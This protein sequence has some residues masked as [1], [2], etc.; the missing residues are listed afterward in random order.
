LSLLTSFP[1]TSWMLISV[2]VFTAL[3]IFCVVRPAMAESVPSRAAGAHPEVDGFVVR[4]DEDEQE[5]KIVHPFFGEDTYSLAS[6]I[7]IRDLHSLAC[8]DKHFR[9]KASRIGF[10]IGLVVMTLTFQLSV[11]I[12]TKQFVTPNQVANIRDA[13]DKFEEVMYNGHTY[14]NANGKQ[15]G[16]AGFFN[17]SA[18]DDME[19]D[20]KSEAC[21]IPFSQLGFLCLIL[22]VWS[23]TCFVNLKSNVDMVISLI[24]YTKTKDD[25]GDCL[26]H[27]EDAME[28]P[29]G[30]SSKP[31][32]KLKTAQET[33]DIAVEVITG[34]TLGVKAFLMLCVFLPEFLTTCYIL[35][36]GSRWLTATNDFGNIVCNAVALEFVLQ[37]KNLL[38]IVFASER[39]KR[40][41]RDT[42]ILPPWSKES[43]G[44]SAYFSTLVWLILS[45]VWV[46]GYVF[47]FQHVLP[48]YKW[49]VHEV[50]SDWLSKILEA[51]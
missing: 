22:T 31:L 35:W 7:I 34:L 8:G 16:I 36:L 26:L 45:I 47:H 25:M 9:L 18:F 14:L 3:F 19:D 13:Y 37:L 50:C 21:N 43:A 2:A 17:A 40:E 48:D 10:G 46:Y 12:C 42:A 38:F 1:S 29:H 23:I 49:D 5:L 24:W 51:S 32:D 30:T 11:I 28:D 15:R 39:A 6:S 41:L 4:N 20:D 27:W 44:W 33:A